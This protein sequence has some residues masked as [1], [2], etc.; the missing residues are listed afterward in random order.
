ML[1]AGRQKRIKLADRSEYGW[2]V[3]DEYK[4][5]ELALDE[6]DAKGIEKAKKAVAAKVMKQKKATNPRAYRPT[7]GRQ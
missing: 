3:V 5:D 6:D 1:L 2:A 7:Q 4:D